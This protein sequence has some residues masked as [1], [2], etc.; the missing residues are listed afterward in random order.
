MNNTADNRRPSFEYNR[1]ADLFYYLLAHMPVDNAAD[2]SDPEYA[3]EMREKL[4]A[5]PEIPQEVIDYYGEHFDRVMIV[6]FFALVVPDAE[7]FKGS[8][9]SCGMLT[10]EDVAAWI[11]QSRREEADE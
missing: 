4:G 3:A 7:A 9:A 11:T 8:L 6:D 10:E 1:F 2:V 5:S